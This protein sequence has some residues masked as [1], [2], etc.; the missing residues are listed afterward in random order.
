MVGVDRKIQRLKEE[1]NLVGRSGKT[2]PG[3]RDI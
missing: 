2:F 3:E 1:V